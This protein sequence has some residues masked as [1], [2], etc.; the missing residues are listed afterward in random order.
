M[1]LRYAGFDERFPRTIESSED[2][3]ASARPG[4]ATIRER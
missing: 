1:T 2:E 3:P 4:C